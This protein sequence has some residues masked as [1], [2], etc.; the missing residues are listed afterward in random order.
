MKVVEAL[1]QALYVELVNRWWG[2][3]PAA[4]WQKRPFSHYTH[5]PVA[6]Q[7]AV[8]CATRN[9][10]YDLDMQLQGQTEKCLQ[11]SID[12]NATPETILPRMN[13]ALECPA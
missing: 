3:C 5:D 6:V 10:A 11:D 9:V 8:L 4:D 1:E 13:A 7:T 2:K 12:L